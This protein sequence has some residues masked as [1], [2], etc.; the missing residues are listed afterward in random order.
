MN[1]ST[2][3]VFAASSLLWL[4][5]CEPLAHRGK[6][7]CG[8]GAADGE[9]HHAA[10]RSQKIKTPCN[11]VAVVSEAPPT[12]SD[13]EVRAPYCKSTV[14][15]LSGLDTPLGEFKLR[16]A[17]ERISGR[18]LFGY[19][20]SGHPSGGPMQLSF[21]PKMDAVPGTVA[22]NYA[23]GPVRHVKREYVGC[24]PGVACADIKVVCVDEL[25]VD[26][27][28]E[29][30][31]GEGELAESWV[32]TLKIQD[33]RDPDFDP[34]TQPYSVETV[35]EPLCIQGHGSLVKEVDP[36][37]ELLEERL[38]V[39]LEIENGALEDVELIG[40]VRL[41]EKKGGDAAVTNSGSL[42]LLGFLPISNHK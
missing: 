6:T 8:A 11:P 7:R 18:T 1:P 13:Q 32:A 33:P 10:D 24:T 19:W 37:W 23:Q 14:Q 2:R 30:S 22:L 38:R 40:L 4:C 35:V 3:S 25:L 12:N 20:F 42:R 36:K 16:E 26:M 29:A 9:A 34:Q 31:A 21:R 15:V 39:E 28:L 17:V 41:R 27:K 5:A